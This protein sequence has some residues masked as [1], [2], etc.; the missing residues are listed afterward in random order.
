MKVALVH[1]WL[2]R[3]AGSE[4]ALL[5]IAD[6]YPDAPIHT[7]V[8]T[9][10]AF[11]DTGLRG[12]RVETS[13]LQRVPWLNRRFRL[14]LPMFPLLFEQFDLDA[15]DLV[16]SNA[17]TAARH[18][19]TRADQLHVSYCYT[20]MRYAWDLYH[21]TLK[22]LNGPLQRWAAACVLHRF[23]HADAL[24]ARRVDL[25]LAISRTV[26]RRI[27][28]TYRRPSVVVHPPVEV[29]RFTPGEDR[30]DFYLS[31]GRLV[32]QKRVDLI[33]RACRE[34]DRPLR[35]VG[36]GQD[37]AALE[38]ELE[39]PGGRRIEHLGTL[40]DE[41][42]ADQLQRCRAL[43]FAADDDFGLAPVEA[44]AAGAPVIAL[45]RGGATETVIE[46]RTGLFFDR[47]DVDSLIEAIRRFEALPTGTF[48]PHALREH[49]ERFAGP[50][51]EQ[52]FTSVIDEAWDRFE[53][54]EAVE[55]ITA[56]PGPGTPWSE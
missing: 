14:A 51:F 37:R 40:S 17:H 16:I 44:M 52:R 21:P 34:L 25:F 1:E 22:S 6:Q 56:N 31:V 12:R 23:R 7:L 10:E 20:P 41:Q 46:G 38:R 28:K 47:Q 50:V 4:R 19:L 36:E 18:V 9:P 30:E 55:A 49:A 29:S 3:F 2:T 11:T 42:V 27:A 33:A 26:S 5:A 15:F 8:H 53:R 45:R 32:S 35:I 43:I 13:A 54:G 24:S 39:S 48:S